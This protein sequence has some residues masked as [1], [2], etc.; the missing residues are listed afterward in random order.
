MLK[1]NWTT[2]NETLKCRNQNYSGFFSLLL[3]LLLPISRVADLRSIPT[4]WIGDKYT[5]QQIERNCCLRPMP[6]DSMEYGKKGHFSFIPAL[7]SRE[8][9]LWQTYVPF[10]FLSIYIYF[11]ANRG[12]YS[13]ITYCYRDDFDLKRRKKK[14][15]QKKERKKEGAICVS[16]NSVIVVQIA[17]AFAVPKWS[18]N[19]GKQQQRRHKFKPS[20]RKICTQQQQQQLL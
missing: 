18:N 7:F 20:A 2:V 11:F 4:V 8:P 5:G 19:K 14:Q 3:L 16:R 6:N 15:Q 12:A 1:E 9:N 13:K 17:F 10:A